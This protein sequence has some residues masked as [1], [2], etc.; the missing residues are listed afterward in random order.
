MIRILSTL[1][2][3]WLGLAV[4]PSSAQD[5]LPSWRDGPARQAIL[6]FVDT[7]TTPGSPGFVPPPERIAVFDN[8][9]TLWVEQPAYTQLLFALDRVRA[10]APQ[11]P[12][13]ATREPFKSALAGDMAGL[14]A[15]G[16]RGLL[17]LVMATHA[18]MTPEAFQATASAWLET[19]RH[20][21]FG[22]RFDSLVYQ[23]MLEL[24]SF[25]R[26]RGFKTYIV[27]GGGIE[28]VRA[29]A[30]RV[31]GIPPE[32]VVGSTIVTTLV[33]QDGRAILI[34]EPKVDFID[35]KAGKPVAINR[36]IGRRP[37]AAFGNS[38]GDLEMLQWTTEGAG[39]RLGVIIRHDDA[40]REYAYDRASHVGRLDKA[41]DMAGARGWTI[42]SMK[43]DW[44][45]I[46]PGNP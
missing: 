4:T 26:I 23:P 31:Y 34:R 3:V 14:A 46:F 43:T 15:A 5:P 42:V 38:D 8:D 21:R 28:L 7:V 35:D 39:P 29:F 36:H 37:I 1:L 27:S 16:E 24:M 10:L 12:D 22:R 33:Q 11:N 25:L 19:A 2:A 20:P 9:G 30:E 44:A 17:E 45:T 18:G 13:W 32:Q 40:E 6:R 41:L